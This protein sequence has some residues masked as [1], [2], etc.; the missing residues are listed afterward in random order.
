MSLHKQELALAIMRP[1]H[2]LV[3]VLRGKFDYC[4]MITDDH[5]KNVRVDPVADAKD[6]LCTA[7]IFLFFRLIAA[8]VFDDM[9]A[10]AVLAKRCH[11][12]LIKYLLASAEF[13]V[14]VVEYY[15]AQVWAEL[16]RRSSDRFDEKARHLRGVR[17]IIRR[18][19]KWALDSPNVSVA[20]RGTEVA[21]V[22]GYHKRAFGKYSCAS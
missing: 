11:E 9:D 1:I 8:Y 6:D 19:K 4:S 10:A 16:A 17:S 20:G 12:K 21:S 2:L 15:I 18:M 13:E 7:M 22:T 14:C 3:K 5:Q